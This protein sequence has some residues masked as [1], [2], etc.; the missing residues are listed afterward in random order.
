MASSNWQDIARQYARRYNFPE[1]VFVRQMGQEAHGQDLTSPAGAQG[2]A[3]IMPATARAWGVKNPHDIHQAY[4]AAARHMSQYAHQYGSVKDALIAYNAG[5]GAIG[6]PLPAETA[7]YIKT[8]MAGHGS[9]GGGGGVSTP[10]PNGPAVPVGRG[11]SAGGPDMSQLSSVLQSLEHAT[12]VPYKSPFDDLS[13]QTQPD[14]AGGAKPSV[15]LGNYVSTFQPTSLSDTVAKI[16]A[17]KAPA[18]QGMQA[19]DMT[20]LLSSPSVSSRD[21]PQAVAQMIQ[22]AN[23]VDAAHVPYL[24]GGGHGGRTTGGKVTPLDCSGAVSRILG[25]D[26]RVSGQF[27]GWGQSGPGKNVTIYAN[28]HHVLMEINGHFFG[29]SHANPQGGAGWIPRSNLSPGY[30]KGFVVRHPKGM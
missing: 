21:V 9:G 24:W 4:A 12:P 16:E 18:Q 27:E 10:A 1:D 2:P 30:L 15:S 19:G 8:I 3:Q 6:K 17:L 26:P 29:T 13:A 28:G 25:I 11:A 5:P 7:N 20:G 14:L 22:E 23:K